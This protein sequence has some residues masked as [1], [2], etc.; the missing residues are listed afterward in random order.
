MGRGEDDGPAWRSG[1]GLNDQ[2]RA[3]VATNVVSLMASTYSDHILPYFTEAFN[4]NNV[5][6]ATETL[7]RIYGAN[8][9][10]N[11]VFWP[12]ERVL[13]GDVF[14]KI[15]DL[16]FRYTLVDQNTHIWNWYGRTVAL[17][18]DGYR[19]NQINGVNCFVINNAANDYRFV[20]PRQR[21]ARCPC[22]NCST[23]APAATARTRWS[24][25]SACG[26]SSARCRRPTPTT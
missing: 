16:G 7:N 22:A 26:R 8:I 18:D 9:N 12:P 1:T 17:G 10:S 5:A 24:P 6:L 11:S 13:D 4:S 3:L 14:D 15:L 23:A 19:I 20:Q 2:I 25:S 21:T